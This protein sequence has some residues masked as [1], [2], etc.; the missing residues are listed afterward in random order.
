MM[1]K[2]E[3]NEHD[4]ASRDAS[5]R[6]R[7]ERAAGCTA[8]SRR[9]AC[10]LPCVWKSVVPRHW[11]AAGYNLL[12]QPWRLLW[13]PGRMDGFDAF[14]WCFLQLRRPSLVPR[15]HLFIRGRNITLMLNWKT[16]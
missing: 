1:N 2:R 6:G 9:P 11:C 14:A 12:A 10:E 13:V 4:D 16:T 5:E 3:S 7:R 8:R 15:N